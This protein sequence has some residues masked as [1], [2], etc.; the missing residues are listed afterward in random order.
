M[1]RRGFTLMELLLTAVALAV[2]ASMAI[3]SYQGYRDR[4]AMLVDETNQKVLAAALKLYAYDNNA[5]P[6]S[7]SRIGPRHLERAYAAVTE[8]KRPYTFFTHLQEWAGMGVAEAV[9]LPE[10]YYGGNRKILMCPLD[11]TTPSP[12]Y[13]S[14]RYAARRNPAVDPPWA[15]APLQAL[16]SAAGDEPLLEEN[17]PRHAN[18]TVVVVTVSGNPIRLQVPEQVPGKIPQSPSVDADM[19]AGNLTHTQK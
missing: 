15:D 11:A 9:S 12:G 4:T 10:K 17:A 18:N 6:G 3:A 2:L 5:L 13:S 1:R 7:L 8:G 16:L 19:D 14:Y